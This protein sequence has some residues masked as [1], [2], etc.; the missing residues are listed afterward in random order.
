MLAAGTCQDGNLCGGAY[1]QCQKNTI[2]GR[3]VGLLKA[4]RNKYFSTAYKVFGQ[5]THTVLLRHN[6]YMGCGGTESDCLGSAP[7]SFKVET[8]AWQV[9]VM[10]ST[11]GHK[12]SVVASA[13]SQLC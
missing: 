6:N 11:R 5:G 4:V 9:I 2:N 7:I 1:S 3:A 12:Y 10:L 13:A 8:G